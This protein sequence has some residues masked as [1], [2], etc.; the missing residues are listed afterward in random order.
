MEREQS[1]I[2]EVFRRCAS[3][4]RAALSI[5][6]SAGD[7]DLATSTELLSKLPGA[8]ADLIELGM[9]F[10][11]PVGDGPS[12]QMAGERALR[13]GIKVDFIFQ[14]VKS[15][16]EKDKNTP[17]ILM[18]Y[19]NTV[20]A[21]GISNFLEDA[22]SSGVDGLIVVDLPPEEDSEMWEQAL[23]EGVTPIRFITPSTTKDRLPLVLKNAHGFLYFVALKGITGAGLNK[24]DAVLKGRIE[25]LREHTDLP[26]AIGFGIKGI[27]DVKRMSKLGDAV[28]IGSAVVDLIK[29][30][31][32]ENNRP[33][34]ETVPAVLDF[35]LEMKTSVFR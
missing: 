7:P 33:T 22:K 29:E 16:R 31:L 17:I 10:S 35:V 19:F 34:R 26:I 27:A 4:D 11:D 23:S 14:M 32:D 15:F 1:R 30:S 5:F 6:I 21:R 25:Q 12:V 13:A 18:G 3:E 28:I 8:G 20:C 2:D 24:D 9:P